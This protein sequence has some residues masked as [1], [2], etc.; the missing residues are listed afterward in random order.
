[1]GCGRRLD[2]GFH[3]RG[4]RQGQWQTCTVGDGVD[5][6]EGRRARAP[7]GTD[8]PEIP[9]S[10]GT[11]SGGTPAS[12]AIA[13]DDPRACERPS[14]VEISGAAV[15]SGGVGS[16]HTWLA[17]QVVRACIVATTHHSVRS[18]TGEG[19]EEGSWGAYDPLPS[20]SCQP[21]PA[22]DTEQEIE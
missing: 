21:R 2:R 11:I 10:L 15:G 20:L 6:Q 9:W 19:T 8:L 17:W 4:N 12:V 14:L 18:Q 13:E 5:F 16:T 22:V 1:M 7:T 3:E